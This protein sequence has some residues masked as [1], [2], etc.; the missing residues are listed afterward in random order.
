[1]E[2]RYTEAG[3]QRGNPVNDDGYMYVT[4][5]VY[6]KFTNNTKSYRPIR[7]NQKRKV[8]ASF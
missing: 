4:L 3:N 2:R 1:M 5:S 8:K 7:R 6:K